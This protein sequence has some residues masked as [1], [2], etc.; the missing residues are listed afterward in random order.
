VI[1]H[2]PVP[3]FD[4]SA[5]IPLVGEKNSEADDIR[6]GHVRRVKNRCDASKYDFGLFRSRFGSSSIRFSTN[7]AVREQ[8]SCSCRHLHTVRY[9]A[10][11]M[12]EI[13]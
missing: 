1:T 11:M 10:R 12:V 8:E 7:L 9:V 2:H 4:E 13:V 5:Y 6:E 3:R